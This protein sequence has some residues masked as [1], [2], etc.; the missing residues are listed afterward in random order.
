MFEIGKENN[1]KTTVSNQRNVGLNI[2]LF[3]INCECNVVIIN[4]AAEC[5]KSFNFSSACLATPKH[6]IR[7]TMK[8]QPKDNSIVHIVQIMGI[9]LNSGGHS[10]FI[11]GTHSAA[12]REPS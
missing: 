12:I 6:D 4:P 10:F 5:S 7:N 11:S 3:T 1:S 2:S 9:P 8:T